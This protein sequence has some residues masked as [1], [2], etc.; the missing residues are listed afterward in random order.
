MKSSSARPTPTPTQTSNEDG[1]SEARVGS[2]E[3]PASV[4][5]LAMAVAATTATMTTTAD[6][7][8][9][10]GSSEEGT[11]QNGAWSTPV[12][13]TRTR[14]SASAGAKRRRSSFVPFE[15]FISPA[16]SWDTHASDKG[17][18]VE[19]SIQDANESSVGVS[20][21][22]SRM[23]TV[24]TGVLGLRELNGKS[25]SKER[26]REARHARRESA[27]A[28]FEAFIVRDSPREVTTRV[29]GRADTDINGD[30]EVDVDVDVDAGAEKEVQRVE[31]GSERV[32][33][34]VSVE[35][36][37][38]VSND[39]GDATV[40]DVGDVPVDSTARADDGEGET[41]ETDALLELASVHLSQP[42]G[43]AEAEAEGVGASEPVSNEVEMVDE[44]RCGR[45]LCMST[46]LRSLA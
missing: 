2:I 44:V 42:G 28:A 23:R 46:T 1:E 17:K 33:P 36:P 10:V 15:A 25:K 12:P 43:E 14:T 24:S 5:V 40:V 3:A 30:G 39:G 34:V 20:P 27:A 26:E 35:V 4:P 32:E 22:V 7:H 41:D 8:D 38:G 11:S 29:G 31:F 18:G 6:G 19:G 45:I 9:R 16:R 21:T 37:V 13:T